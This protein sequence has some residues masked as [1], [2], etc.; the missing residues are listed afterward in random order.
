MTALL[1]A[2]IKSA[3]AGLEIIEQPTAGLLLIK[4]GDARAEVAIRQLPDAA[5]P[6]PHDVE[7]MRDT[8]ARAAIRKHHE[9]A[10]KR[11]VRIAA[12]C[13]R[14]LQSYRDRLSPR[15]GFTAF[16]EE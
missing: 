16:A 3:L 7:V 9:D 13:F 15:H 1:M 14:A 2:K 10:L 11:R 4:S 6:P 5:P 8:A 12:A